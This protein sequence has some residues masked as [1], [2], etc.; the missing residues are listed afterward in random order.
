MPEPLRLTIEDGRL[1]DYRGNHLT[2][3][4]DGGGLVSMRRNYGRI[5]LYVGDKYGAAVN[6]TPAQAAE[7]VASLVAALAIEAGP[8]AE[9]PDA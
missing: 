3:A 2:L 8:P 9:L 6:L 7:L 1:I 4:I 5:S